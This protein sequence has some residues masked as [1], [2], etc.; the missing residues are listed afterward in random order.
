[1]IMGK[2]LPL[3]IGKN[4]FCKRPRLPWPLLNG[5]WVSLTMSNSRIWA[6]IAWHKYWLA[7]YLEYWQ[8][9]LGHEDSK[10]PTPTAAID[11]EWISCWLF[12]KWLYHRGMKYSAFHYCQGMNHLTCHPLII[13]R[14]VLISTVSILI[15]RPV[16][17]DLERIT[18]HCLE[19]DV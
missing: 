11:R 8:K 16:G 3:N 17:M 2:I 14:E 19:S 18:L 4:V 5:D 1:M 7:T 13:I 10:A 9:N 6:T 15:A 12:H